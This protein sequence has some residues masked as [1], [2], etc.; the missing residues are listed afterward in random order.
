M[1]TGVE[2]LDLVSWAGAQLLADSAFNAACPGGAHVGQAPPMTPTPVCILFV[3]SAPEYLTVNGVH[4]WT[5]ASLMVKMQGP[6]EQSIAMRTAAMRAYA[7]LHRHT[8]AAQGANIIASV[9]TAQFPVP[10]PVL[11]NGVLWTSF[12]QLYRVLV[13]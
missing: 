10:E 11:V 1:S 9:L 7:V 5:D 8:G 2:A 12:V 6:P 4:I 3:Q 13:Q